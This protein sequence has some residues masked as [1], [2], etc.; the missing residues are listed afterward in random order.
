M[1][2]LPDR[3]ERP[4]ELIESIMSNDIVSITEIPVTFDVRTY[5]K[6]VDAVCDL[7][8]LYSEL[9]LVTI[10]GTKSGAV[11]IDL[12][13]P[14]LTRQM[15]TQYSQS[16]SLLDNAVALFGNLQDWVNEYG[17][18]HVHPKCPLPGH[19]DYIDV[20]EMPKSSDSQEPSL[21]FI[22]SGTGEPL[23]SIA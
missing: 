16:P 22:C 7:F 12:L 19:S 21:W 1:T 3:P 2:D 14:R 17:S 20:A 18:T 9:A 5:L 8:G 23:R 15:F 4:S 11:A 10:R 6:L 13:F